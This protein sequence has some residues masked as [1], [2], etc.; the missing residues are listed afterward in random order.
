MENRINYMLPNSDIQVGH[1][2]CKQL[3]GGFL[4]VSGGFSIALA[5]ALELALTLAQV[6]QVSRGWW[7]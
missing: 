5:L 7:S 4:G 2:V 6:F 1:H 3:I